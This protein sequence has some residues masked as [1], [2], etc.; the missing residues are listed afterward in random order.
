ML[1]R[2]GLEVLYFLQ[3]TSWSSSIGYR[4][5]K[6]LLK[7]IE[8]IKISYRQRRIS[9]SS[10]A[11]IIPRGLLQT[12][13][14]LQANRRPPHVPQRIEDLNFFCS[15]QKTPDYLQTIE[16]FQL[17]YGVWKTPR[18]SMAHR[19]HHG[20]LWRTEIPQ[21]LLWLMADRRHPALLQRIQISKSFIAT[22]RSFIA[23][24]RPPS[25]LQRI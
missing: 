17:F 22:S 12:I 7:Q 2:E 15:E 21:I 20:L 25:L 6:G 11:N 9:R 16:L 10:I 23:Y 13:V 3:K 18:A 19:R 8:D 24:R 4:R 5:P 14:D 1:S